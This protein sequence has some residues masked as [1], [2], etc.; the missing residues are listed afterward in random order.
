MRAEVVAEHPVQSGLLKG[1]KH[2]R[3]VGNGS[4]IQT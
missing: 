2:I 3:V 4:L 1:W